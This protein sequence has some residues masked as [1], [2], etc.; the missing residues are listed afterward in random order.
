MFIIELDESKQVLTSSGWID[1]WWTDSRLTWNTSN[2]GGI[3]KMYVKPNMMWIPDIKA[4]GSVAGFSMLGSESIPI[5]ALFVVLHL[6]LGA[7]SII[8][9][10]LILNIHY[11]A[12]KEKE[13]R[14]L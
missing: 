3:D 9:N 13:K 4:K 10:I 14:H 6:A 8:C 7:L 5:I 11:T 12:L 2:Y 1:L